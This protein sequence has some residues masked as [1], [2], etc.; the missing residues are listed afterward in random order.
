[1]SAGLDDYHHHKFYNVL[2]TLKGEQ[3][4]IEMM[5]KGSTTAEYIE[6]WHAGKPLGIRRRQG[7]ILWIA[8]DQ[9]A[10]IDTFERP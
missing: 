5:L 9:I 2:I 1:M 6:T 3:D 8:A 10:L 7:S 4:P